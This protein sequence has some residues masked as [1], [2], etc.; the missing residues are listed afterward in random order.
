MGSTGCTAD[1]LIEVK[2]I[3]YSVSNSGGGSEPAPGELEVFPSGI[4]GPLNVMSPNDGS[5]W[6]AAPGQDVEINLDFTY[7]AINPFALMT[8]LDTVIGLVPPYPPPPGV[9]VNTYY[10]LGTINAGNCSGQ[11]GDVHFDDGGHPFDIPP[12]SLVTIE[13]T[14]SL[15]PTGGSTI[16]ANYLDPE[17][18]DAAPEPSTLWLGAPLLTILVRW[19]LPRKARRD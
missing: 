7:E 19:R 3:T 6:Q 2:D 10:C 8:V 14:F 13:D 4:F 11:S 18:I 16:Y 15:R 9:S 17:V 5:L 12:S 1:G